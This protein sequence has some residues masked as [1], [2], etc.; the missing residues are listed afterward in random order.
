M[1]RFTGD[2][3]GIVAL[4]GKSRRAGHVRTKAQMNQ[5]ARSC[6]RTTSITYVPSHPRVPD[7]WILNDAEKAPPDPVGTNKMGF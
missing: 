6:P 2:L 1:A 5:P 3:G 4:L 7:D